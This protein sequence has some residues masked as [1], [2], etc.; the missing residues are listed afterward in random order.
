MSKS[1]NKYV[2]GFVRWVRRTISHLLRDH[3]ASVLALVNEKI[4]QAAQELE[5]AAYERVKD[6]AFREIISQGINVGSA[7]GREAAQKIIDDAIRELGK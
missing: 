6:A 2:D 5:T 3:R 7:Y 4:I 1:K